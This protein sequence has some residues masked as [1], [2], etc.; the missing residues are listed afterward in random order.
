M[1]IHEIDFFGRHL[2]GRCVFKALERRQ[3]CNGVVGVAH[4]G[5][6]PNGAQV[7]YPGQ[8]SRRCSECSGPIG[9]NGRGADCEAA[10]FE[11]GQVSGLVRYKE[12]VCVFV[13]LSWGGGEDILSL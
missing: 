4:L 7:Q 2:G 10:G 5:L 6:L 1:C 3:S 13:R 9:V 12:L 11:N 8:F